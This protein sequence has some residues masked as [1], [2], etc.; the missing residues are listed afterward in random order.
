MEICQNPFHSQ[1]PLQFQISHFSF[2]ICTTNPTQ[3]SLSL[4]ATKKIAEEIQAQKTVQELRDR[5]GI[6]NDFTPQEEKKIQQEH[7]W[8]LVAAS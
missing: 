1:P 5:F 3:P 7:A 2:L 8:V 6:V 4:L